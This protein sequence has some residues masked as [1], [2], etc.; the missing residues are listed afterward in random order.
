MP[1]PITAI[2]SIDGEL[3][4]DLNDPSAPADQGSSGE[5][6]ARKPLVRLPLVAIVIL[7]GQL[8]WL[9]FCDSSPYLFGFSH[10][11]LARNGRG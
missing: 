10:L 1:A 11:E 4:P 2:V 8:K 6:I 7:Y 5:D 3:L 9:Y